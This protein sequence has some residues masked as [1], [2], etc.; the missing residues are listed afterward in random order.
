MIKNHCRIEIDD[1]DTLLEQ[2]VL[3]ATEYCER[4]TLHGISYCQWDAATNCFPSFLRLPMN[5][6]V[7]IVS[8]S[9]IDRN[10]S[11]QVVPSSLYDFDSFSSVPEIYLRPNSQWPETSG[12]INSVVVRFYAGY[13]DLSL[14]PKTLIQ[15]ILILASHWYEHRENAIDLSSASIV[16]I[17]NGVDDLLNLFRTRRY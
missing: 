1:D 15:A 8:V 2:Y 12:R 10:N 14:I 5:N 6:V 16:S 7:S 4:M 9:Y 3:S 17:P 11:T 13:S